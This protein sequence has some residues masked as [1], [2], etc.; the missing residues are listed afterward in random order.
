MQT[1]EA[2]IIEMM[3]DMNDRQREQVLTYARALLS[4]PE[5]ISGDDAIRIAEELAFDPDEL[6]VMEQAINE[7]FEP[8]LYQA[9]EKVD[10]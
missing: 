2:E 9:K 1:V 6:T 4:R 5:A 7:V 10:G 8:H 3:R